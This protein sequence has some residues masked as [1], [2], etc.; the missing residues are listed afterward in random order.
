[1]DLD[2]SLV[3]IPGATRLS[4]SFGAEVLREERRE[5]LF[6]LAHGLMGEDKA[7]LQEHFGEVPQ[8]ELVPQVPVL[9]ENSIPG[10]IDPESSVG[11]L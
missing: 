8:A 4:A 5:A 11:R 9:C 7:P 6:P 2:V 3:N 10:P 1:V